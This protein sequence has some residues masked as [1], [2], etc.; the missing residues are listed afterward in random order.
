MK[1]WLERAEKAIEYRAN[2]DRQIAELRV[3]Y[4]KDKRKAKRIR[5]AIF[6]R[7]TGT[8][9]DRSA[10]A[11]VH[12]DYQTAVAA[13]MTSLLEYEKLRNERDSARDL[14]DFWR[15]YNKAIN[16]GNVT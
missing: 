1:D 6:L 8:V 11:E 4:E 7:V 13:E 15:S 14:V 12:D 16:E 10:Q 5:D 9:A 2:T 3:K